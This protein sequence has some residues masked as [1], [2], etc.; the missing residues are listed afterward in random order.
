MGAWSEG[1][2]CN[3]NAGDWVWDLEKSKGL[4]T[5]LAPIHAVIAGEDDLESSICSEALAASEIIAAAVSGD[6]SVIPEEAK[7]WLSK[8][9]GMIFGSKPKIETSHAK[10]ALEA[11]KT[12]MSSSELQELWEEDGENKTWRAV[13][14]ALITKLENT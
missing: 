10:L 5:L 11:V 6:H 1:N 9:Q 13:Q 4:E 7:N 3:D 8:K 12:I 14:N 2:F